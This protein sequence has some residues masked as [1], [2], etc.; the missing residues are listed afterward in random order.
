MIRFGWTIDSALEEDLRG[1][2]E[3]LL[4]HKGRS[5]KAYESLMWGVDLRETVSGNIKMTLYNMGFMDKDCPFSGHYEIHVAPN[6]E[7]YRVT[8]IA[9][10]GGLTWTR[11]SDDSSVL[12][13]EGMDEVQR[14]YIEG[15]VAY[16][17]WCC[18]F[19]DFKDSI[20]GHFIWEKDYQM[21]VLGY[22]VEDLKLNK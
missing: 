20:F 22:I 16:T 11:P 5:P 13:K 9:C 21:Q 14:T 8:K 15:Y 7:D 17:L 3:A 1:K 19:S 12:S 6:F 2:I 4:I 18:F 10:Y